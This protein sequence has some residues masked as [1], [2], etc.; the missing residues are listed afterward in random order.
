MA[1]G[2]GLVL[3][4]VGCGLRMVWCGLDIRGRRLVWFERGLLWFGQG[5]VFGVVLEM[6]LRGRFVGLDVLRCRPDAI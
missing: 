2:H 4:V 6:V 5:L 1:L 3:S